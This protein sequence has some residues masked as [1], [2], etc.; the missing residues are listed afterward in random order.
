MGVL[1][2]RSVLYL[3]DVRVPLVRGVDLVHNYDEFVAYLTSHEMRLPCTP[4][5][6]AEQRSR[7][8]SKPWFVRPAAKRIVANTKRERT[9]AYSQP[10]R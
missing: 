6:R 4:S 5:D 10:S 8:G 7:T 9:P 2:F 3:D 1:G